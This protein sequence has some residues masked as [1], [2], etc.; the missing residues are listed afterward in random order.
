MSALPS[1]NAVLERERKWAK[2]VALAAFAAL[3]LLIASTVIVSS[4][5][6]DGEAAI[7]R[8]AELHRSDVTLS[9]ILQAVGLALLV[10]PL[11]YLF[12]AAQARSDRVHAQLIGLIVAAPLFLAGGA[13][14]N[15]AAT[16]EAASTFAAGNS[17]TNLTVKEAGH[18]CVSDRGDDKAKFRE[19][20]GAGRPGLADWRPR[21]GDHSRSR[22]P[23]WPCLCPRI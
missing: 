3:G 6:G 23:P 8:A 22:R 2:P 9:S 5:S 10:F 16:N 11:V 19:E 1:R 4:I 21:A 17:S 13:L 14:L 15:A 20:F 18:E 7:L 12:R